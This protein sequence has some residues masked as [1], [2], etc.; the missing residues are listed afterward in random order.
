M[1]GIGLLGWLGI[2]FVILKLVGTIA[3]PWLWV[4]FP[5]ILKGAIIVFQLIVVVL[6]LALGGI[7]GWLES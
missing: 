6:V 3:W 4:L 5:F 1:K 7:M 2:A